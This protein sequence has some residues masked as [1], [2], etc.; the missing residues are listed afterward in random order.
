LGRL[1][2]P[3]TPRRGRLGFERI[4]Q[5]AEREDAGGSRAG[6]GAHAQY[7]T[8]FQVRHERN[9]AAPRGVRSHSH[10]V[11]ESTVIDP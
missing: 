6:T 4:Q 10:A 1:E 9:D 8:A 2:G 5:G 11:Q 3:R 7:R